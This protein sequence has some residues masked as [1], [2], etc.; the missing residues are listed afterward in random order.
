MH[1]PIHFPQER[2]LLT[3]YGHCFGNMDVVEQFVHGPV[4]L[5]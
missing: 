4:G 5:Q 2:G 1:P 3:N